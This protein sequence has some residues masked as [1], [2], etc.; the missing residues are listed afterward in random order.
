M[1]LNTY[2][3]KHKISLGGLARKAG[4][5][6]TTLHNIATGQLIHGPRVDVALR[7]QA[8]TGGRVKPADLVSNWAAE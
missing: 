6:K 4:I 7:I 2:L 3:A 8:A 5:S 1:Q